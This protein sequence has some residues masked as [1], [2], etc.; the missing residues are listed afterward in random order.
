MDYSWVTRGLLGTFLAPNFSCAWFILYLMDY[1]VV[2]RLSRIISWSV[3]HPYPAFWP[4]NFRESLYL[5]EESLLDNYS[6]L[7]PSDI[8]LEH[9]LGASKFQDKVSII[10]VAALS[11]IAIGGY[12]VVGQMIQQVGVCEKV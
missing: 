11:P 8:T 5:V 6:V 12:V 9:E 3:A 10:V 2:D 1:H 7:V 4:P